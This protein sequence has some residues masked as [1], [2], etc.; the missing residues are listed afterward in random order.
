MDHDNEPYCPA[1]YSKLFRPKGFG[2]GNALSTDYGPDA[3]VSNGPEVV[4]K[5]PLQSEPVVAVAVAVAVV[6]PESKQPSTSP[7]S[8]PSGN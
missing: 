6:V 1:C 2:F 3:A 7:A 4:M 5:T 8:M